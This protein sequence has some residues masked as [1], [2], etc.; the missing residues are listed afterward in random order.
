MIDICNIGLLVMR[1]QPFHVGHARTLTKAIEVCDKVVVALGSTQEFGTSK[2]PFTFSE[3][4]RMIKNYCLDKANSLNGPYWENV[5]ITGLRDIND[6]HRWPDYVL[7]EVH[8]QTGYIISTVFGG[9][10]Y[11][12]HWFKSKQVKIE[13]VDRADPSIPFVSG[14]MIR[15][16]LLYGDKRW[17][18]FIPLCNWQIVAKKFNRLEMLQ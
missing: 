12:C 17:M 4:K 7:D 1:G 6:A 11:D 10:S 18:D 13:I 8:R 14:S 2:N 15:E 3:R 5:T 9:T 16:M